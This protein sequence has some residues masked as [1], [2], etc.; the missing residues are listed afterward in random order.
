MAP[1]S[2]PR[3][4]RAA[5]LLWLCC[6]AS[7]EGGAVASSV[8]GVART[9]S[10][11]AR[12][13]LSV[14]ASADAGAHQAPPPPPPQSVMRCATDVQVYLQAVEAGTFLEDVEYLGGYVGNLFGTTLGFTTDKTVI[15]TWT[16]TPAS[17]GKVY[18]TSNRG[19]QLH[20]SGGAADVT[21][22][23]TSAEEW[24]IKG[25]T[26]GKVYLEGSSG[27]HLE[28]LGGDI[29]MDPV[30]PPGTA[31][32]WDIT[33]A[34]DGTPACV[35][36]GNTGGSTPP[37]DAETIAEGYCVNFNEGGSAGRGSGLSNWKG[38]KPEECFQKCRNDPL[39]LQ[40]VYEQNGPDGP[41]CWTGVNSMSVKPAQS[42]AGAT[43]HCM[44]KMGFNAAPDTFTRLGKGSCPATGGYYAGNVA[45]EAT[46]INVCKQKCL[47][48][49]ECKYISFKKD[50]SC[51]R[52]NGGAGQCSPMTADD[53]TTYRRDP[54]QLFH[55]FPLGAGKCDLGWYTDGSAMDAVDLTACQLKCSLEAQCAYVAF[56]PGKTCARF[57]SAAKPCLARPLGIADHTTYR[58]D[59]TVSAGFPTTVVPSRGAYRTDFGRC[60]YDEFVAKPFNRPAV[61]VL[62]CYIDCLKYKASY[63]PRMCSR[64]CVNGLVERGLK[65]ADADQAC[66]DACPVACD[67]VWIAPY[68]CPAPTTTP[69]PPALLQ[70]PA[71]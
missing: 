53:H 52:Y 10:L 2:A 3:P 5:L 30:I 69:A 24:L 71:V 6:G 8:R 45:S 57:S 59:A 34:L 14:A 4:W 27:Q 36:L 43:D 48:E 50:T 29:S 62:P 38:T 56:N 54:A 47:S 66:R 67:K 39:C 31:Q 7:L 60:I 19:M 70:G 16:L 61:N 63:A 33:K 51:S 21:D 26:N 15:Q 44:A 20:D 23:K 37:S 11:Q 65:G 9:A 35:S 58:R 41:Q 18:I 22:A 28:N 55:Y 49:P 1:F 32:E 68:V 17:N 42:R 46:D 25:A 64:M 40:A 13:N 12:A